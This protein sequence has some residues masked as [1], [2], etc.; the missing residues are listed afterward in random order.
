LDR[1]DEVDL[2]TGTFSKSF[3]SCGGFVAGSQA[4]IEWLRHQA[5]PFL[6]SASLPP[7]NVATVL[8]VLDVLEESTEPV[9]RVNKIAIR[10]RDA[11]RA[12]GYN[13]RDCSGA[14]VPIVVGD[15]LRAV[16][17]WRRF[18]DRGVYTNAVV[19]PA[20]PPEFSGLRTSYMANHTSDQLDRALAVFEELQP[21]FEGARS[22]A[23]HRRN[24]R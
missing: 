12:L 15:E 14:I 2:I 11:L 8:A 24:A 17:A 19:P 7:S 13:V 10:M 1:S 22:A 4:V 9:G 16:Q 20:V 6:F 5:R 18:M 3:A 23:D 21:W